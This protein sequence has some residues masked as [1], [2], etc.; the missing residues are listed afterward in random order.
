MVGDV[1]GYN[2]GMICVHS[3]EYQDSYV[4]M[5]LGLCFSLDNGTWMFAKCSSNFVFH[6]SGH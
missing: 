1:L 4:G 5:V 3:W 2:I 6:F